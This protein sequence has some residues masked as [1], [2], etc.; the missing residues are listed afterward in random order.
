MPFLDNY[1]QKIKNK[2]KHTVFFHRKLLAQESSKTAN[3]LV[4]RVPYVSPEMSRE[5]VHFIMSYIY[6]GKLDCS[7]QVDTQMLVQLTR[8]ARHFG[9]EQLERSLL[10]HIGSTLST[11]NC[12]DMFDMADGLHIAELREKCMRF[13]DEHSNE[14]RSS[15][16]KLSASRLVTLLQ[17]D[18][19]C[20][21]EASVLRLVREWHAYN[22]LTQMDASVFACVRLAALDRDELFD[23]HLDVGDETP[24]VKEMVRVAA[25]MSRNHN[26]ADSR[27]DVLVFEMSGRAVTRSPYR[28]CV[29][30]VERQENKQDEQCVIVQLGNAAPVNHVSVRDETRQEDER[31]Y[32]SFL[33]SLFLLKES[34]FIS[35]NVCY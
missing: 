21:S 8:M 14:L 19:F 27:A 12:V 2:I 35:I 15:L 23:L 16:S 34:K 3:K 11:R 5:S 17:R 6:S 24:A 10:F 30:L 1:D 18:S 31:R 20:Q 25:E 26:N 7:P 32:G 13:I 29:K 4:V 28:A 33:F 9:L 22:N